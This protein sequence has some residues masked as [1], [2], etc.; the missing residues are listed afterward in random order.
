MSAAI[1]AGIYMIVS[2]LFSLVFNRE[3]NGLTRLIYSLIFGIVMTIVQVYIAKK[4]D[5][6][7]RFSSFVSQIL[8]RLQISV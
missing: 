2:Y 1:M 4:S 6:N 8:S 3:F 7:R 5:A